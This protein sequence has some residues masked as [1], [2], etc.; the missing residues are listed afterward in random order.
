MPKATALHI[1]YNRASIASYAQDQGRRLLSQTNKSSAWTGRSMLISAKHSSA[2]ESEFRDQQ[3]S[4]RS[5]EARQAAGHTARP[6]VARAKYVQSG[7]ESRPNQGSCKCYSP[8]SDNLFDYPESLSEA[9]YPSYWYRLLFPK[10]GSKLRLTPQHRASCKSG[11]PLMHAYLVT[12]IECLA[13]TASTTAAA[14][15]WQRIPQEISPGFP[16]ARA[17]YLPTRRPTVPRL[18]VS[19]ATVSNNGSGY[20][21][22]TVRSDRDGTLGPQSRVPADDMVA[23][24]SSA[25]RPPPL[26]SALRSY[27]VPLWGRSICM[28]TYAHV[29][30]VGKKQTFIYICVM[31][32]H[33][34]LYRACS[35]MC[36]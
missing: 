33:M 12:N 34:L 25:P 24:S 36:P 31:L 15:A 7:F 17:L 8:D 9:L 5:A 14:G 22:Q 16:I 6:N 20:P 30:A 2:A 29:N 28:F 18:T 13:A 19:R 10:L 21:R 27:D 23:L 4:Q 3:R 11:S 32:L 26:P 1:Q 35:C